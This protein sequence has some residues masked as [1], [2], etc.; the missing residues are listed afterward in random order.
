MSIKELKKRCNVCNTK[1]YFDVG[2]NDVCIKCQNYHSIPLEYFKVKVNHQLKKKIKIIK[3]IFNSLKSSNQKE[4]IINNYLNLRENSARKMLYNPFTSLTFVDEWLKSS[5]FLYFFSKIFT[6]NSI[7]TLNSNKLNYQKKK[8]LDEQLDKILECYKSKLIVFSKRE[9]SEWKTF[10][11]GNDEVVLLT[12]NKTSLS[13]FK[14]RKKENITDYEIMSTDILLRNQAV[15]DEKDQELLDANLIVTLF[16]RSTYNLNLN[17]AETSIF[18]YYY[19]SVKDY[20]DTLN[21]NSKQQISYKENKNLNSK[22]QTL[23]KKINDDLINSDLSLKF[24]NVAKLKDGYAIGIISL[25]ILFN[26]CVMSK[27]KGDMYKWIGKI[28]EDHIFTLFNAWDVEK[29]LPNGINGLIVHCPERQSK[30]LADVLVYNIRYLIIIESKHIYFLEEVKFSQEVGKFVER[31]KWLKDNYKILGFKNE[32]EIISFFICPFPPYPSFNIE[33]IKIVQSTFELMKTLIKEYDMKN[34][35]IER[36]YYNIK[37]E[38]FNI[39]NN[40]A[41]I[42][43]NDQTKIEFPKEVDLISDWGQIVEINLNEIEPEIVISHFTSIFNWQIIID[44]PENI[45]E[46]VKRLNPGILVQFLVTQHH[47]SIFV[48]KDIRRI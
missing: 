46:E 35:T 9:F 36:T 27:N 41:R 16:R 24:F 42:K 15:L 45:I 34:K 11:K 26:I 28:A 4:V 29:T 33:N 47:G 14:D 48:I 44:I 7:K 40:G 43:L 10:N 31:V 12:P 17:M 39:P 21:H 30:E 32:M 23:F 19:D 18:Q 20:L 25:K 38:N 6:V 5:L 13:I 1:Y 22:E 3:N 8:L 37:L 2:G